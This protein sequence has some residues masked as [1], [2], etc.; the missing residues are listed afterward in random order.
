[1]SKKH[2][3][4]APAQPG[5][6]SRPSGSP[7]SPR[8]GLAA[9]ES[10]PIS[11]RRPVPLFLIVLL[12]VLLFG[13]EMYVVE[14]GGDVMGST[15]AFPKAVFDPY[16]TY[17]DLVRANPVD[18]VQVAR[19]DGKLVFSATCAA[20]HQASGQ[21]LAGQ[22][23]PLAGS[24]WANAE[25]AN[26]IIRIVLNGA[27]GPWTV[28]GVQFNNTMLA[29]RDVLTDDQI[30]HVLTYERSEWGNK[31]PAVTPEQVRKVRAQTADQTGYS[32]EDDLKKL[33]D[34]VD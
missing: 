12:V 21:G 2:K 30:A 25:G 9:E 16:T 1:M 34:K 3:K 7:A 29:W 26:R 8:T 11:E 32:Q 17:E 15:G 33:P 5:S 22:F 27:A 13:G 19:R 4:P 28:N 6:Q 14:H 20:C 24:D 23:P 31:A 18:P 10:E